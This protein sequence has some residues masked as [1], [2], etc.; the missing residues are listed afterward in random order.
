MN[1]MRIKF[2]F[3]LAALAVGLIAANPA[4]ALYKCVTPFS[5]THLIALQ[6]AEDDGADL[7]AQA[8]RGRGIADRDR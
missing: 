1:I 3:N 7:R 5:S 2:S 6:P 4:F 8:R